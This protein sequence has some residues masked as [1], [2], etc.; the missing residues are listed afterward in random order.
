MTRDEEA[1]FIALWTAGTSYRDMA[2]ALGIPQST[3][4]TRARRLQQQGTIEPRPRGGSYPR[5]Q[6][7]DRQPQ[8]PVQT[9]ADP[10]LDAMHSPVYTLHRVQ[11]QLY[12]LH[13][14]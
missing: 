1:E 5:Q 2:Q 4:G 6:A 13:G 3:V 7:L 12:A 10:P 11:A 8:T 14:A 9:G